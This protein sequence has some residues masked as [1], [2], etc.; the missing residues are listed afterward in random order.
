MSDGARESVKGKEP[1]SKPVPSETHFEAIGGTTYE[2]VAKFAGKDTLVEL[3]KK[4]LKRDIEL[5][6]ANGEWSKGEWANG[7]FGGINP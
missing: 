1:D 7:G 3:L 4:M 6:W 2:V 5:E